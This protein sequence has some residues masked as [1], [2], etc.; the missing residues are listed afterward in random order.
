MK[1]L[2]FILVAMLVLGV[3]LAT[4]TTIVPTTLYGQNNGSLIT[5][6][7]SAPTGSNTAHIAYD[8]AYNYFV[9]ISPTRVTT[10]PTFNILAGSYPPAWRSG[11]G[12]L[13]ISLTNSSPEVIGPLESARFENATG[14][15]KFSTTNVTAATMAILKIK[16]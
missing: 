15:Y 3:A 2:S 7:V 9:F 1:L 10:T 5:A 13:K 11:I 12:D 4:D 16:R 6:D 8:S 14:Y